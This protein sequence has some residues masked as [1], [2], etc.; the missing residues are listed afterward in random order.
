M[1]QTDAIYERLAR[2]YNV[3]FEGSPYPV[4]YKTFYP[5]GGIAGPKSA[6]LWSMFD[7]ATG[8]KR[9]KDP[10]G[11]RFARV[12]RQRYAQDVHDL[13]GAV[14][15]NTRWSRCAVAVI[16]SSTKGVVNR[17]TEIVKGV[18]GEESALVTDLTGTI[19][20]TSDKQAA[21]LGGARSLEAHDGSLSIDPNIASVFDTVVVIDD[22][23]T[24]GSSFRAFGRLLES[25][26]FDGT[27][28]NF[29]FAHTRSSDGVEVCLDGVPGPKAAPVREGHRVTLRDGS[30]G[31]YAGGLDIVRKA[32]FRKTVDGL[33]R[34]K[35][36]FDPHI[37][38]GFGPSPSKVE[39][40][41]D[42]LDDVRRRVK[43]IRYTP[44]I[45]AL[46]LDF[47]QTLIDSS[48]RDASYEEGLWKQAG[49]LGRDARP[50]PYGIYPGVERLAGLGIPFAIVSN[51]SEKQLSGILAKADIA[52]ALYPGCRTQ[53]AGDATA[54]YTPMTAAC[55]PATAA[56]MPMTATRT[57]ATA[58]CTPAN[59]FS[60]PKEERDGYTTRHYKP[61]PLGVQAAVDWLRREH[62]E[63]GE[64]PRILGLG[65]TPEDIAAYNAAGI[66]SA[67]ALW[68]VPPWCRQV[69]RSKWGAGYAF[70]QVDDFVAW[71]REGGVP[72]RG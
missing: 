15:E 66:E 8:L 58:A 18:L 64:R 1:T 59:V 33:G 21:H 7:Y 12:G 20:R 41:F 16:P 26:G 61:S 47:D 24:S 17:A 44:P 11:V 45:D 42:G 40:D 28:V 54:A 13:L 22:I 43:R 5:T 34:A 51:R 69:A 25:I 60:F 50:S 35:A 6:E 71:C 36:S 70:D 57:P 23:V 65:N 38:L 4:F 27:I 52:K 9:D 68:G 62:P 53:E 32:R 37:T 31:C 14:L 39:L 3:R 49:P 55:T 63:M 10:D 2:S 67:L 72:D 48:I 19:V 56:C 46:V 29:A 30:A